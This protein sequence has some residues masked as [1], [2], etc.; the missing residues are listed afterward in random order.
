MKDWSRATLTETVS[1]ISRGEVSSQDV[2]EAR[3]S[4]VSDG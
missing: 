2:V 4:I 1:A 3:A